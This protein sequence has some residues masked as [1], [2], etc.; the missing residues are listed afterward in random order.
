MNDTTAAI[1]MDDENNENLRD[2]PIEEK[3]KRNKRKRR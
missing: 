3:P 2:K 1:N